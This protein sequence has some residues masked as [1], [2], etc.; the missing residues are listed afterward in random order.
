MLEKQFNTLE[1]PIF[2]LHTKFGEDILIGGGDMPPKL[3]SKHTSGGGIPLPVAILTSVLLR[4]RPMCVHT[5]FQPNDI[6]TDDCSQWY[7]NKV[8]LVS[9]GEVPTRKHPKWR[10]RTSDRKSDGRF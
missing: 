4:G 8:Y 5:K 1:D 2:Y 3:N 9:M 10:K 6:Q 7:I